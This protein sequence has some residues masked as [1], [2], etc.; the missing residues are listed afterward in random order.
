M[1]KILMSAYACE[2]GK[3][4]EPGAG[5]AAVLAA[6]REHDIWV[7]TRPN[8]ISPLERFLADHP[9]RDR[10]ALHGFD[11]PGRLLRTKNRS[12]ALLAAYYELWQRRVGDFAIALDREVDFALVHH[13]TFANYWT[14][15]G[16]AA[17]DKPLVWGPVGGGVEVPWRLATLLGWR[18]LAGDVVR[19]GVRRGFGSRRSV[20][21]AQRTA[22]VLFAQNSATRHRLA[23]ARDVAILPN[24]TAVGLTDVPGSRQLRSKEIAVV[25]RLI[26]LKGCALAIAAFANVSHRD[27][28]LTFFGTGP[29]RGRIER[30]ARRLGMS[31]RIEFAGHLDRHSVLAR[32]ARAGVVLHPALHDE[33]PWSVAEALSLAT[34]VVCLGHG[35]PG[36]LVRMWPHSPAVPVVPTDTAGT[37]QAMAHAIDGFLA[38]PPVVPETPRPPAT[39]FA[40]SLLSAYRRTLATP[41]PH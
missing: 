29:E 35:G 17:V 15:P 11:V 13:V 36:E 5:L 34:P 32:M 10:I 7:I 2:P 12:A 41:S 24:A 33:A 31:D 22:S 8:N 14:P 38:S 19:F 3:G 20:V 18:G 28:T 6:A 26:P 39:D 4:G 40:A 16:V 30:L 23:A 1:V 37:A 9:A 27:A 21:Q 25:G